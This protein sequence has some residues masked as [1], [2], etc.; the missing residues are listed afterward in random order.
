MENADI[1]LGEY[2]STIGKP[3][4][5]FDI[6]EYITEYDQYIQYQCNKRFYLKDLKDDMK[7]Y[8]IMELIS[9]YHTKYKYTDFDWV[10]K[11]I[12]RRKA[13]L[14]IINQ[15]KSTDLIKSENQLHRHLSASNDSGD[16]DTSSALETFIVLEKFQEQNKST[17]I[18]DYIRY[19]YQKITKTNLKFCFSDFDLEYLE[20]VIELYD[21]G[22]ECTNLHIAENMGFL[23]NQMP[24]FN[25][26]ANNFRRKINEYF[27]AD[28]R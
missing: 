9:S 15:C 2:I 16:V 27:N 10:T 28:W 11:T 5:E 13:N 18:I 24:E 23:E 7:Q 12:I 25:L 26:K 22:Y 19:V 20:V 8:I 1:T 6:L 14:F 21:L 17:N 4:L 3:L